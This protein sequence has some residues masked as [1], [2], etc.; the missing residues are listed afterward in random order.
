MGDHLTF[1]IV[2][3]FFDKY[4]RCNIPVEL[5]AIHEDYIL[6]HNH[7]AGINLMIG[8]IENGCFIEDATGEW[9]IQM[10]ISSFTN[11]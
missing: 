4:Q 11:K 2:N 3:E 9:W 7:G 10:P 1:T 8:R 5:L 6:M